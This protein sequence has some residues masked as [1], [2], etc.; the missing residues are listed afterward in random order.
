LTLKR[1]FSSTQPPL[2]TSFHS[3][4]VQFFRL[5]R[6]TTTRGEDTGFTRSSLWADRLFRISPL[7]SFAT[8]IE[9]LRHAGRN[10]LYRG[11]GSGSIGQLV[12]LPSA[13]F[14]F[15]LKNCIRAGTNTAHSPMTNLSQCFCWLITGLSVL[16][17]V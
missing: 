14:Q 17:F 8:N 6:K 10:R 7:Y 2:P 5:L 12:R 11:G 15:A 1:T 3:L 9:K 4:P 13:F 16:H